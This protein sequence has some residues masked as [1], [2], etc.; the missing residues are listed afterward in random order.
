MNATARAESFVDRA[1][2]SPLWVRAAAAF[3]IAFP[4][5]VVF[6]LI[7]ALAPTLAEMIPDRME[8][9]LGVESRRYIESQS[10]PSN[11]P[12]EKQASLR[13]EFD[14]LKIA[15]GVLTSLSQ[16]CS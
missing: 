15:A 14:K 16:T 12:E 11:L 1:I 13:A 8:R 10:R 3:V 5:L 7:P 6:V 2:V 9:S 4:V